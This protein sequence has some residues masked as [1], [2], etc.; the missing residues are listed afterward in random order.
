MMLLSVR[1]LNVSNRHKSIDTR[2]LVFVFQGQKMHICVL[3]SSH[4]RWKLPL[5]S[6]SITSANPLKRRVA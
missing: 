5:S 3:G 4:K 2:V 6:V 1:A